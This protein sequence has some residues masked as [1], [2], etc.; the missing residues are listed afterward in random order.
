MCARFRFERWL[1]LSAIT[2][3]FHARA[4]GVDASMA[5]SFVAVG[6]RVSSRFFYAKGTESVENKFPESFGKCAHAQ[7]S[8]N[9]LSRARAFLPFFHRKDPLH[10]SREGKK[11]LPP[12]LLLHYH[13]PLET[14]ARTKKKKKHAH[15]LSSTAK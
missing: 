6:V 3:S 1:F 5:V 11:Q 4:L 7:K 13:S 10:Q 2:H 14:H 8:A 15:S 12:I 9:E